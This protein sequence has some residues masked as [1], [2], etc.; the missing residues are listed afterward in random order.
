MSPHLAGLIRATASRLVGE[1][2]AAYSSLDLAA[3]SHAEMRRRMLDLLGRGIESGRWYAVRLT[4]S[5][6]P[7]PANRRTELRL[8]MRVAPLDGGRLG[9]EGD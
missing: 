2:E 5:S 6:T 8:D 7:D 4:P 1:E 3:I 9:L